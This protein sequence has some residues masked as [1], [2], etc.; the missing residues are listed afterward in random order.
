MDGTITS[1]NPA[2]ER[3]FGRRATEAVG[4]PIEILVPSEDRETFERLMQS[5]TSGG[6]LWNFEVSRE[7]ASG[8]DSY[9][10]HA[11]AHSEYQPKKSLASPRSHGM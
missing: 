4:Q 8:R 2:A 6:Q 9:L 3:L 10:A 1:W 7:Q 11:V 5:V